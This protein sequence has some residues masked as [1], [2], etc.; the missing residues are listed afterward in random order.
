[1]T[2]SAAK[3]IINAFTAPDMSTWDRFTSIL[4]SLGMLIPSAIAVI[5]NFKTA[6]TALKE[7]ASINKLFDGLTSSID[8]ATAS[9]IRKIAADKTMSEVEKAK[10]IAAKL[11]AAGMGEEAAAATGAAIAHGGAIPT[12]VGLGGAF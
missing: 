8:L 2:I 9:A 5:N 3:G 4:M 10:A 1:M 11:S 7:V 12:T 6:I